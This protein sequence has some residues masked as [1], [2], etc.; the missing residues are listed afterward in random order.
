M[1]HLLLLLLLAASF[2]HARPVY[3]GTG[4]DGIYLASFD[5]NTGVLSEPKLAVAYPNPGFLAILRSVP[6]ENGLS[7]ATRIA[8]PFPS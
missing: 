5:E 2:A 7:A 1:K 3:I 6:P 8:T 4:A